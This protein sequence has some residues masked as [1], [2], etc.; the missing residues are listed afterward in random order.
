MS[1]LTQLAINQEWENLE[2]LYTAMDEVD[3]EYATLLDRIYRILLQKAIYEN[4]IMKTQEKINILSVMPIPIPVPV[5]VS[6]PV[7]SSPCIPV[8]TLVDDDVVDDNASMTDDEAFERY[9]PRERKTRK[10]VMSV[11]QALKAGKAS[12]THK[13]P[14]RSLKRDRTKKTE[15]KKATKAKAWAR[16]L[17]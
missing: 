11:W 17:K 3:V 7:S 12:K 5:P 13:L 4:R 2:K 6:K 16:L 9:S 8:V 10:H 15:A 1:Q 14:H